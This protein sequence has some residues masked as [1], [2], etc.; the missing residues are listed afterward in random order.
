M[1]TGVKIRN[2]ATGNTYAD[3]S[4]ADYYGVIRQAK[5]AGFPGIIVEHAFISNAS[6]A[7]KYLGSD[8][9]LKKL[10][11]ADAAG[12]AETYGL[13]RKLPL[14]RQRLPSLQEKI[15]PMFI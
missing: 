15:P 11:I 8:E 3:G 13:K 7:K 12:I 10:G 2:S 6:D 4:P 5:Q 9:A 1:R 14:I